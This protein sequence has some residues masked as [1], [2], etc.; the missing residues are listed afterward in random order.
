MESI[1]VYIADDHPIVRQGFIRV[2]EG[3]EQFRI[4]GQSFQLHLW[5]RRRSFRCRW[6]GIFSGP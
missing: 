5:R 3:D 4:V 2:I 6:Q 1:R